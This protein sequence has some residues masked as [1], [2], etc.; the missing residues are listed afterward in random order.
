MM[1]EP[2]LP[3]DILLDVLEV[4]APNRPFYVASEAEVDDDLAT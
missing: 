3:V 4:G 1:P 2:A